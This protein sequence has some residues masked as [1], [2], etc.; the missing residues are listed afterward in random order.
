M[1]T[2][3]QAD[4]FSCGGG[5]TNEFCASPAVLKDELAFM[6]GCEFRAMTNANDRRF[7]K[8]ARQELHQTMLA[9]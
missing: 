1:L 5:I 7:L 9:R 3:Y 6:K 2:I 8:F 4:R